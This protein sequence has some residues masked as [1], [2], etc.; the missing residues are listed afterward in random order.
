MQL[1]VA[2]NKVDLQEANVDRVVAQLLDYGVYLEQY[3]GDVP[4]CKTSVVTGEGI[5][6]LIELII[7]QAEVMELTAQV[8]VPAEAVVIESQRIPEWV[9]WLPSSCKEVR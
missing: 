5:L 9:Q 4:W 8:K 1:I 6:N 3:G 7:L 2:I